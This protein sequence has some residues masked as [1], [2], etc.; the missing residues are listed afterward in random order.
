MFK[1]N[2][3][4][5]GGLLT[6]KNGDS[7]SAP[8]F[9]PNGL[10]GQPSLL[11][12]TRTDEP[13][14]SSSSQISTHLSPDVPLSKPSTSS[15]ISNGLLPSVSGST[16]T[17]LDEDLP[18]H[19]LGSTFS[20]T[21]VDNGLLSG[22]TSHAPHPKSPVTAE[23]YNPASSSSSLHIP[24]SSL[25]A[26]TYDGKT[27]YLKRK[28]KVLPSLPTAASSSS[29][30][31]EMGNLLDIPIHR[32]M[33]Q[34]SNDTA[35]RL[36]R[37]QQN[38]RSAAAAVDS[39]SPPTEIDDVLWVDR[40]RPHKFTDLV[41]NEKVARD[42]MEWVKEWDF[43]VFGKSK[44]KKRSR[45]GVEN[46]NTDEFKRPQEKVLLLSG[47]PGLGKTT[48]AHVVAR[49]AGYEVMEI[50]ASDAR[51]GSIID[52]RIKPTLE[53]GYAVGST[54]PV[55]LIIDEIDGATGTG[56]NSNT[57]IH[58]LV[59]LITAKPRK[60]EKGHKNDN[61]NKGMRPLLRPIIC[62]CNDHNASSLAKLRPIASQIRFN[63]PADVHLVKRLKE[64]CQIEGLKADSRAIAT[65]V[66]IAQGDL[67]GCL[68]TLQFVKTRGEDVTEP[69]IRKATVGMKEVDSTV[70]SVLNNVFTPLSKKRVRELGMTDEEDARYVAR[71]S[72]EIDSAGRDSAVA[73]GCFGH[74][75]TRRRHD[76]NLD[77]HEKGINWLTTFDHF[78]S[79][80]YS[81]GDFALHQYLPYTLTSFYPL[82]SER[83]GEKVERNNADWEHLQ[84]TRSNEEIYK[85]LSR[86]LRSATIR[87]G[88]DFRH[89][90][91][92]PVL[93]MEFSP[94]LNRI[95][96]PPLRPVNF[97]VIRP[98]EKALMTRLVDIMAA[99]ELRFVHERAE[100]G[101]LSFRLDPPIDV[102][103][104]YDG[105]RAT[106]I[107]VSR[108]AVRHLVS[109]EVDAKL[110]ARDTEFVEKG[111]RGKHEFFGKTSAKAVE[112]DE[113]DASR[114]NK[115]PKIDIADKPPT[116]F[117]GRPITTPSASSTKAAVRKNVEKKYRV[118]Y[119][120]LEGNSAAV[121]RPVKVNSFL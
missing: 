58:K 112:A 52:D 15:F 41:G 20:S 75:A 48:L 31:R 120:F 56:D 50:N 26:T 37:E 35:T 63:R 6:A 18:E 30:T 61:R 81:D 72:R 69:V 117:F 28:P 39:S 8:T 107:S 68:N 114:A 88:G 95:I 78:S 86:C 108:Y 29:R 79:A 21:F 34:L 87:H 76:A 42:A 60:K 119:K 38:G 85:T 2:G 14:S 3:L 23:I 71:L 46:I 4:L 55:L 115:R 77:R 113:D 96:S 9:V 49:H 47:P 36:Q 74:Y 98:Q 84:T 19:P 89:L 57:F 67:R 111:K 110:I 62:I 103:I 91:S 32:L 106:D 11:P 121:R 33:D 24:R 64:V 93:Q 25:R 54:K 16:K 13:S 10:L 97:Q 27:L 109:A 70:I 90:V 105:K 45:D 99:L 43:C 100:D 80:M 5:S 59:Q 82:F 118:T 1:P 92:S 102:F 73:S 66:T 65:L 101:T 12:A 116:D 94:Y 22:P 7:L 40:Y 104:T 44:G 53:S 17:T 51:S 83:S